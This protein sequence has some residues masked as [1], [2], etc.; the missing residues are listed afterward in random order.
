[1]TCTSSTRL[2]CDTWITASCWLTVFFRQTSW[3]A[4]VKRTSSVNT[5]INPVLANRNA[6]S[7]IPVSLCLSLCDVLSKACDKGAAENR[8]LIRKAESCA[9]EGWGVGGCR[10][11]HYINS[12]RLHQNSSWDQ[13]FILSD[14]FLERAYIMMAK[15]INSLQTENNSW[16]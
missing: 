6:K 5:K 13:T 15:Q 11:E 14:L 4:F 2:K 3:A 9:E 12:F 16:S 1:M 8:L 7:F 10:G